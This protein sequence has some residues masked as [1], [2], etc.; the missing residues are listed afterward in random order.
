MQIA[1]EVT[2]EA[3]RETIWRIL[4]DTERYPQ[5]NPYIRELHGKLAP[6]EPIR[7][8]FA[9][10]GKIALPAQARVLAVVLERELRW[11]GHLLWEWLFRAEHYHLLEAVSEHTMRLRHGERFSGALAVVLWPFL[12]NWAPGRYRAANLALKQRAESARNLE[13]KP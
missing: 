5:W 10:I 6:G 8:R 2:I 13:R 4:A 7:F 9:L 3:S 11:A 1:T 12:R